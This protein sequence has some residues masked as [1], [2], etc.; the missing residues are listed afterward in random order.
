MRILCVN[1]RAEFISGF[2]YTDDNIY[3]S[4]S[5]VN[6]WIKANN[7]N[8]YIY[9]NVERLG[10][11]YKVFVLNDGETLDEDTLNHRMFRL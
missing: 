1:G 2:Y 4:D 5:K 9:K 3:A 6:L 10:K 11:N 8:N 7:H